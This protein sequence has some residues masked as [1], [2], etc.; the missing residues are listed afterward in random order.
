MVGFKYEHN[1]HRILKQETFKMPYF[2]VVFF[3]Y[4]F[5]AQTVQQNQFLFILI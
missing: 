5:F 1:C 3:V 2:W 4:I